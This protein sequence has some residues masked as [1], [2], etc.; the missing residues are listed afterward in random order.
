MRLNPHGTPFHKADLDLLASLPGLRGIMVPKAE[1]G[2]VLAGIAAVFPGV[3]LL[4]MVESAEGMAHLD[5]I[6]RAPGVVRIGVGHIDMQADLGMSCDEDEA[7]LGPM[8]FALVVAS[9]RAN[10]APPI[11]GVTTATTDAAAA[12]RDTARGRRFGFSGKLCIHP[13]Q[14]SHVHAA[15]APSPEKL[16][17]AKRVIDALA[18]ASGG[19][20]SV[21]GKMVDAAVI[22]LARQLLRAAG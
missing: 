18:D 1:D 19:A 10:I 17:W 9:R 6:A 12:A 4:P 15:F 5:E 2:Q 13:A 8:R 22:S 7:E 3:Y 16:A 20:F 11:D 14:V 21:D